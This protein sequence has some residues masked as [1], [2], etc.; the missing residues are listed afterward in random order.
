M[1]NRKEVKKAAKKN[2]RSDYVMFVIACLLAA[3]FG[4]AYS[5]TL[6]SFRASDTEK[7]VETVYGNNENISIYG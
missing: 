7:V 5:S 3:F 1:F 4:S 6:S 2:V